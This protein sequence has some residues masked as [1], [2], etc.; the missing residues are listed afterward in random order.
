MVL[1]NYLKFLIEDCNPKAL[2]ELQR[3]G[4]E[5]GTRVS[6]FWDGKC[7][8]GKA[9]IRGEDPE[10]HP[11]IWFQGRGTLVPLFEEKAYDIVASFFGIN[12]DDHYVKCKKHCHTCK[13]VK[14]ALKAFRDKKL[15]VRNKDKHC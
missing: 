8:K 1:S 11:V 6:V 10:N 14:N 3:I 15:K 2:V 12:C 5:D 9:I 13:N 7:R 4:I